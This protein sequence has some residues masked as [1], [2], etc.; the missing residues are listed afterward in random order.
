MSVDTAGIHHSACSGRVVDALLDEQ[1]FETTS[2]EGGILE[3]V[4]RPTHREQHLDPEGL[5][6]S[7][8]QLVACR[9]PV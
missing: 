6:H 5:N 2:L 7:Q 9:D 4:S 8:A 1:G 3:V